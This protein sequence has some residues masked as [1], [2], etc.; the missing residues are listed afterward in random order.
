MITYA[1]YIL[2]FPNDTI[3]SIMHDIDV[4]KRELPIDLLEFFYL[5]PLPGSEDHLKLHKAGAA[6]DPDMNKY[7][8]NHI[9]AAHPKMSRAGMGQG[10]R[11]GLAALLHD[12]AYRNDFAARGV[13]RANASNALFLI[14][15]FKGAIDIEAHSSA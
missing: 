2:G 6:L 7:D 10:Q 4:I 15:W 3:E 14:T 12:R 1:G 8:F 13:P 9:C 5:T 11:A